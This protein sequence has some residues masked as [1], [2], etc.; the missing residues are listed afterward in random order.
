MNVI[1]RLMGAALVLSA[2]CVS[3][4]DDVLYTQWPSVAKVDL[5]DT[6]LTALM[7]DGANA[8]ISLVAADAAKVS[9]NAQVLTFPL[10]PGLVAQ[11]HRKD[12]YVTEDGAT[13]WYGISEQRGRKGGDGEID[14]DPLASA[15]LVQ[16]GEKLTGNILYADRMFK[17]RP[18]HGDPHA[19]VEVDLRLLPPDHPEEF[20]SLPV[21]AMGPVADSGKAIST[22][23]VMVVIT[24]AAQAASGDA[25]GLIN[26][27]IAETNRGYT[28][29]GVEISMVKAGAYSTTY[30]ESGSF[31]TDLARFRGTSDGYMDSFHS[32]RNSIAADVAVLLINNSSSCG[33]ASGIGSTASTAFAA[34]HWDCATGYY[35]FGHE[36]GHLQSARH[37]PAADPTTTPYAY[38]HGYRYDAGGW[39][40]IMAYACPNG[41]TRI[42]YWSN[43]GK[44]YGG[45]PMGTT[46]KHHNQR[47][48]QNTK[49]TIAAFR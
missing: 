43:P 14:D 49:A 45:V 5:D 25:S 36:V 38:G 21:V 26:L 23:R 24:S 30:R 22:I 47:V 15:M 46:T 29:S 10:A 2:S 16:N 32:T 37:D 3:A 48:L 1:H 4:S 34:A 12:A 17:L 7:K 9:V 11:F 18:T 44:T 8:S 13:V 27:A 28:N 31:S 19:L 6:A 41:C 39:R 42:N 40:T 35:S 33:L 20:K